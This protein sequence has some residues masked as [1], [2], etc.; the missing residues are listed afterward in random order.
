MDIIEVVLLVVNPIS[1]GI[2]KSDLVEQVKKETIKLKASLLVFETTGEEDVFN[3]NEKIK[4]LNPCRILIAGGDGT[5]KITAEAL[6]GRDI[7]VGIIPSGSANGLSVNLYLPVKLEDQIR[8]AL[9]TRFIHMDIILINDEYCL[10]MSD[11]G[12]NAELVRKYENASV[13]G[14]IGYLLQSIPTLLESDYPFE[15]KVETNGATY[16]KEGILLA[17]ANASSYG[18]GAKVNPNGR[19]DDGRFEILI[20]K[21]FDMVEILKTLRNEVQL[22]PEFVE[23]ISTSEATITCKGPVAFQV[24]GEYLGERDSVH[25][26]ILPGKLRLA[27]DEEFFQ[28]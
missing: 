28:Q 26:K 19:I 24:D 27:V 16:Q 23:I 2:D 7:P 1:G 8:T 17:I 14:K 10:H 5:I 3:L 13:R 15:F 9:G 11:F 20:F 22:D 25:V 6:K 12:L 4:E 18:T 21:N